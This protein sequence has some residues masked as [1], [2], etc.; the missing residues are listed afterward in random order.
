MAPLGAVADGGADQVVS[1]DPGADVGAYQGADQAASP[2]PGAD[3]VAFPDPGAD[4]GADQVATPETPCDEISDKDTE[5]AVSASLPPARNPPARKK[6]PYF[7]P[8]KQEPGNWALATSRYKMHVS[9]DSCKP[10][11]K[12][13]FKEAYQQQLS[14]MKK[15][16]WKFRRAFELKWMFGNSAMVQS[17]KYH[18]MTNTFQAQ[19]VYSVKWCRDIERE[20]RNNYCVRRLD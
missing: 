6:F 16:R 5:E 12:R 2:D 10:A 4:G 9:G 8:E 20:G 15:E 1:P 18:A 17:L 14:F 13:F 11:E 3:Q 19:L 7:D